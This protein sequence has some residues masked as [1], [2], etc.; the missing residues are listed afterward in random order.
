MAWNL[1]IVR[2]FKGR[3]KCTVHT[4]LG[5]LRHTPV[6]R[7]ARRWQSVSVSN[8]SNLRLQILI[9][10]HIVAVCTNTHATRYTRASG[11]ELGD[12]KTGQLVPE[13]PLSRADSR[14]TA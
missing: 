6:H 8:R 7:S 14:L 5:Y 4:Q 12:F 13:I 11:I 1:S 10:P 2:H 9:W 3:A